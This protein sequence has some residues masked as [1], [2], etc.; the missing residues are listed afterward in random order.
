VDGLVIAWLLPLAVVGSQ[1]AAG[2]PPF[3]V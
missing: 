3:T 1:S 2:A